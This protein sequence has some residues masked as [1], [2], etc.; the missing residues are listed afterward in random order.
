MVSVTL[1]VSDEHNIPVAV[2]I[3]ARNAVGIVGGG[4]A[5]R[6]NFAKCRAHTYGEKTQKQLGSGNVSRW[7]PNCVTACG[8]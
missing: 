2:Q 6:Q 5:M 7:V 1:C 3:P 8:M 4:G